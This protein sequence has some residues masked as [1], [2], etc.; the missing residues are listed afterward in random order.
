M[1]T[2]GTPTVTLIIPC[3]RAK[4]GEPVPARDLYTGAMFRHTLG[5]ALAAAGWC[6]A[7]GIP[8]RV[9]IL[10]ARQGLIGL[11]QVTGPYDTKMG[12]PG[13]VTPAAIARQAR[14]LGVTPGDVVCAF[15]PRLYLARLD[16]A[17]RGAGVT[18][19]DMYEGA[20][21]IG[22]QR[23][24]NAEVTRQPRSCFQGT[25]LT[26]PGDGAGPRSRPAPSSVPAADA[27]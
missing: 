10:S 6:D 15:L 8:A 4:A 17:L 9:L 23:H 25:P 26:G 22:E 3:S 19:R 18:V 14:R 16:E 11:D 20:R 27:R 5:A 12:G 2:P 7:C 24:V 13:S 21:G 1:T